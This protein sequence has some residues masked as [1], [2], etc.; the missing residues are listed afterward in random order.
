MMNVL[1]ASVVAI[2]LAGQPS[3]TTTEMT[4]VVPTDAMA[5]EFQGLPC[6]DNED[7]WRPGTLKFDDSDMDQRDSATVQR[8]AQSGTDADCA[9]A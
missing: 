6:Y 5:T 8:S 3:H 1:A 7:M 4:D 2:G 9:I